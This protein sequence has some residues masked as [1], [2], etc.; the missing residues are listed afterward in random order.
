MITTTDAPT[1]A[2]P[3]RPSRHLGPHHAPTPPRRRDRLRDNRSAGGISG[4]VGY[5][6]LLNIGH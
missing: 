1:L 2:P 3:L 6:N 4:K 5:S